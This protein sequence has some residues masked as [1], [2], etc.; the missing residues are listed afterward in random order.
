MDVTSGTTVDVLI[1]KSAV[2]VFWNTE[3]DTWKMD[4]TALKKVFELY[5]NT[6]AIMAVNFYGTPDKY[7]ES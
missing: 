2:L 6:K 7:D 5:S 3:Y 4:P 1:Y